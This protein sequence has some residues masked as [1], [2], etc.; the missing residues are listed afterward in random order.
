MIIL[1]YMFYA[2]VICVLRLKLPCPLEA[3]ESFDVNLGTLERAI[4]YQKHLD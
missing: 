4:N 1:I 2:D 3:L